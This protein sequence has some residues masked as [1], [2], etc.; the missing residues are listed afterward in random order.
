MMQRSVTF[1]NVN[2]LRDACFPTVQHSEAVVK[3]WDWASLTAEQWCLQGGLI[4]IS[5]FLSDMGLSSYVH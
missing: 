4:R 2:S 1:Y 3:V 5:L